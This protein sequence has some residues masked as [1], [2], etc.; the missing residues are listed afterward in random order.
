MIL[1]WLPNA[2]VITGSVKHTGTAYPGAAETLWVVF[3][4]VCSWCNNGW[5]ARLEAAVRPA[6]EP[7]RPG[8]A[9]GTTML[10]YPDRPAI[11]ATWAVK[12]IP[13]SQYI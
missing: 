4:E 13:G 3:H 12:T 11:L 1:R 10:L 6:L 8:P 7:L 5:P 2:L 9:P